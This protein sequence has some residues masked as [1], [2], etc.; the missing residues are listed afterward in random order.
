MQYKK[1]N[2]IL[3]KYLKVKQKLHLKKTA[4][5]FRNK[6]QIAEI[7]KISLLKATKNPTDK[8]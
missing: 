6:L 4:L 8:N 5:D 3:R 1:I 2:W 7:E